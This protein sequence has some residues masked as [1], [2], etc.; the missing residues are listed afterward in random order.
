MHNNQSLLE[1]SNLEEADRWFVKSKCGEVV[2]NGATWDRFEPRTEK[3]KT[4][5]QKTLNFFFQILS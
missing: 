5:I 4:E 1:L 3:K 2:G